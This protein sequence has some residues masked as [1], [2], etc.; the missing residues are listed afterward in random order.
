MRHA[1]A[2]DL[3]GWPPEDDLDRLRTA[4]PAWRV[5]RGLNDQHEP[6]GWYATRRIAIPNELIDRG[7]QSRVGAD[8]CS[9]LRA[10]LAVQE[11]LAAEHGLSNER[12]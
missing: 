5:W 8:S 12:V 2:G 9:G 10:L 1:D 11:E 3:H 4:F 6:T 7:L